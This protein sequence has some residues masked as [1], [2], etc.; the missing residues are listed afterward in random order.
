[1]TIDTAR[2]ILRGTPFVNPL[3]VSQPLTYGRITSRR[4]RRDNEMGADADVKKDVG[5][6]ESVERR[7]DAKDHLRDG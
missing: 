1:M 4:T 6:R 5:E 2:L 7:N 3:S